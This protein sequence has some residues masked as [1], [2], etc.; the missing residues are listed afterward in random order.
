MADPIKEQ[1]WVEGRNAFKALA[2]PVLDAYRKLAMAEIKAI[3]TRGMVERGAGA[4][5]A[6]RHIVAMDDLEDARRFAMRKLDEFKARLAA[7]AE[8]AEA[9]K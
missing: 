4:T 1:A 8:A 7:G 3:V 9:G 6:A 2:P 5:D